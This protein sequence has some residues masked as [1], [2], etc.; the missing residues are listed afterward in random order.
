MVLKRFV[1]LLLLPVLFLSGCA[2]IVGRDTFPVTINSNPEGATIVVKDENGVKMYAG[3]TPTT[4]T[5]VAGESYFHAKSYTIEFSNPG[6]MSQTATIKSTMSGWYI[7]NILFGGLIGL[8]IVDPITGK[9][10]KIRNIPV[11]A[12]LAPEKVA[13]NQNQ[14]TLKIMTL[15]QI[16]EDMRKDLVSLN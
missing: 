12:D 14:K 3:R 1:V 7:G 2:S 4:I 11:F 13:S 6:Y 15:S 16:P 8:L 5:V 10:W 9:M